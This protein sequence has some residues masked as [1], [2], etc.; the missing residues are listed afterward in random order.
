VCLPLPSYPVIAHIQAS[1]LLLG[2]IPDH[3]DTPGTLKQERPR[4]YN[5]TAGEIN[6]EQAKCGRR[7]VVL[8]IASC[9]ISGISKN[10]TA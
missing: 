1:E 3:S 4:Q 9:I 10:S 2:E 6:F 8:Y 5:L 7:V